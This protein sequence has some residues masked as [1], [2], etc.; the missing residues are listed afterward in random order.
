VIWTVNPV[1]AA[2][3]GCKFA[4][5]EKSPVFQAGYLLLVNDFSRI[6]AL[7]NQIIFPFNILL[8]REFIKPDSYTH[9]I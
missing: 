8:K 3:I 9:V 6:D 5:L 4:G 2:A 7:Y 1:F